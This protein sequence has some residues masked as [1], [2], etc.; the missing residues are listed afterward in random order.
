MFAM[1]PPD[2]SGGDALLAWGLPTA[3]VA[4]LLLAAYLIGRMH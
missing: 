2:L 1:P 3:F 4:V